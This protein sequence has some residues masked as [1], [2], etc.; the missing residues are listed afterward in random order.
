MTKSKFLKI[1]DTNFTSTN[2]QNMEEGMLQRLE[3]L[4]L[5]VNTGNENDD[6]E[7]LETI[8][9]SNIIKDIMGKDNPLFKEFNC[10]FFFF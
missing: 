5:G 1:S 4:A 9:A 10:V 6:G 7:N 3:N 8:N 2:N